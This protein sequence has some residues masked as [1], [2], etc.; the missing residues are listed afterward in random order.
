MLGRIRQ[1]ALT[2]S[3]KSPANF[4]DDAVVPVICPTCKPAPPTAAT[5]SPGEGALAQ[6]D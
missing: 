5:G 1:R 2:R 4:R 3:L 6:V